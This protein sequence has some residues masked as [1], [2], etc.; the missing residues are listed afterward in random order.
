MSFNQVD[1]YNRQLRIKEIIKDRPV[2]IWGAR[3][4]GCGMCR[5][6]E[7]M[8]F[9][10]VGF[11][12]SDT[13]FKDK[14]ILGYNVYSP[15]YLERFISDNKR[16]YIM[17]SASTSR[18]AIIHKC[19]DMG[20]SKELDFC[21]AFDFC[22][23]E[24][25]IDIVGGCN[26]S[27]PSCPRGNFE[28]QPKGG[29]ISVDRFK[30]IVKK[31]LDESPNVSLITL[32]NWGEPLL[33]PRLPDLIQILKD[34][35]I[36]CSLST[37]FNIERSL[38]DIVRAKPD[39][40]KISLS[41][42]YQHVYELAHAKGNINLVKSNLYR[43]KY[44]IDRYYPDLIVEVIYHKYKHN[45]GQDYVK[46]RQLCEELNFFFASC[47]AFLSPAEK[48]IDYVEGRFSEEDKKIA[49]LLLVKIEDALGVAKSDSSNSCPL[50][51]KQIVI[52]WDGS[53]SLC[54][55]SFDPNKRVVKK[56]FLKASI[57][58]IQE[59]KLRNTLCDKCIKYGINRYYFETSQMDPVKE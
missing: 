24:Y 8:N 31:I 4:I 3:A 29:M 14:R 48:I 54:C 43:L 53:V 45:I 20:L 7:R 50:L 38:K 55:A 42:Y 18:E 58:E 28:P 12:D 9:N 33:H 56:D 10:M 30:Q 52:N 15:N 51:E 25:I 2:L 37:N 16:P 57:P 41:G 34:H 44:F 40:L 36:F 5:V 23:F 19:L 49:D 47:Y 11:V 26:L 39:M 1:S 27:C 17:I 59:A 22:D 13:A 35:Q 32:Y 6:A 21:S 46:M